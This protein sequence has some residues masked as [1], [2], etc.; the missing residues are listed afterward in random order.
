MQSTANLRPFDSLEFRY[1]RRAKYHRATP[2]PW[3]VRSRQEA[4]EPRVPVWQTCLLAGGSSLFLWGLI[5][6]A[7]WH[8]LG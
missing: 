2:E 7:V 1:R 4:P 8:F 5:G 3:S 6:T